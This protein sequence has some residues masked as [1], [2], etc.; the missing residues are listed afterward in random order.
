VFAN[1]ATRLIILTAPPTLD[2]PLG[3]ASSILDLR[4]LAF[5]GF[6][7]LVSA[8][9]SAVVPALKYSRSDLLHRIKSDSGR[10]KR[11]WT[12]FFFTGCT[13]GDAGCR[14]S[15]VAGGSRVANANT[16]ACLAGASGDLI[17]NTP[18]LHHRPDTPGL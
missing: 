2:L 1:W 17:L 6:I 15:T 4:V 18:S 13:G 10:S 14:F 12:W 16:L 8:L 7:A 9:I 3:R 5:T 11:G